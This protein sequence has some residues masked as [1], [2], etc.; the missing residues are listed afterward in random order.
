MLLFKL[1]EYLNTYLEIEN[2][3]DY[4][5]NGLQVE[6]SGEIKKIYTA[7]DANLYTINQCEPDSILLV[8]HGLFWGK[9]FPITASNYKKIK[10][11]ISKNIALYAS[12]LPLD[13]H[14]EVGNNASLLKL[15]NVKI[16]E[17]FG[18]YHGIYIGYGGEFEEEL[19]LYEITDRLEQ[20][21]KHPVNLVNF[22]GVERI[23]SVCAVSGS[24]GMDILN[25]FYDTGYDLLVTGESSHIAHNYCED[26]SLCVIFGTHY[27]TET[28]GIR[29][30]GEKLSNEFTIPNEFIRHDTGQ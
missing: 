21:L 10:T 5:L 7:V 11:L 2:F 14:K 28:L 17:E 13:A 3:K 8:H 6:N 24:P 15:L 23:K 4:S 29:S 20:E 9:D 16:L 1:V 18:N 19:S 25:E 30:L 12:H 22:S 27:A 26:N